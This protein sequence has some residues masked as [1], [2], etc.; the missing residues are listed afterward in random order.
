[1][2]KKQNSYVISQYVA[3]YQFYPSTVLPRPIPFGNKTLWLDRVVSPTD[4]GVWG[5]P[6]VGNFNFLPS[7]GT[8]GLPQGA[9]PH[10]LLL[11][12]C[13]FMGILLFLLIMQLTWPPGQPF[14]SITSGRMPF[15]GKCSPS[16]CPFWV[17]IPATCNPSLIYPLYV[18][19][20]L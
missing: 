11:V 4:P 18:C 12:G 17:P 15:C 20:Y 2:G 5:V 19:T 13:P 16:Y 1:M 7:S 9:P 14:P 10:Q 6:I 8:P 3:D